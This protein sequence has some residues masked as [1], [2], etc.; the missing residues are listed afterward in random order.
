[1]KSNR[2]LCGGPSVGQACITT[3]CQHRTRI[4]LTSSPRLGSK[5]YNH[6]PNSVGHFEHSERSNDSYEIQSYFTGVNMSTSEPSTN[7]FP[8]H[9]DF[10]SA[11]RHGPRNAS[12]WALRLDFLPKRW[13]SWRSGDMRLHLAP[14]SRRA[15]ST[16]MEKDPWCTPWSISRKSHPSPIEKEEGT[17]K[18]DRLG[19]YFFPS[20]REVILQTEECGCHKLFLA[21]DGRQE[22]GEDLAGIFRVLQTV[23]PECKKPKVSITFL[24]TF[25]ESGKNLAMLLRGT[26]LEPDRSSRR[27]NILEHMIT[28]HR[29]SSNLQA[30][31]KG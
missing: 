17:E 20:S 18:G 11:R 22:Y 31:S 8:H 15:R 25:D 10:W 1:M 9:T 2:G 4:F 28:Y 6:T 5:I 19:V 13:C 26:C 7:Y 12:F 30:K 27:G 14:S 21:A 29:K 3:H 16:S 23:F 24:R